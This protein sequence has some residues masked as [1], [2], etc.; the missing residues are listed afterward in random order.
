MSCK[1]ETKDDNGIDPTV[2]TM[3]GDYTIANPEFK[4]DA[5]PD[6]D[7]FHNNEEDANR[8]AKLVVSRK[9]KAGSTLYW[10]YQRA[11]A[12]LPKPGKK[13]I[14]TD[15]DGIAQAIIE[16]KKIDTIP[17]NKISETYAALDMGT[18]SEPLKKWKA[19][20]WEFFADAM[21]A[22]EV[23]P[24]KNMLVVCEWFETIWPKEK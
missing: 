10:F 1:G 5:L 8:L 3:W 2:Y 24:S 22:G 16:T 19:A 9:K 15:F 12:D 21:E 20:H 17:F 11:N 4:N 7:Y 13:S 18:D 14:V 23:E 6:V